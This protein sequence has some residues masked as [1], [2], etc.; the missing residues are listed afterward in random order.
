MIFT[1]GIIAR[2]LIQ[3]GIEKSS[4]LSDQSESSIAF[5]QTESTETMAL[6]VI[7]YMILFLQKQ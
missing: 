3:E 4:T 7:Q 1:E 2:L 5:D 6:K